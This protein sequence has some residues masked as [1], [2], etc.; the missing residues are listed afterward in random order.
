M[1]PFTGS[2]ESEPPVRARVS[3]A[4]IG[5]VRPWPQVVQK[6]PS[7]VAWALE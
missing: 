3:E 2:P 1:Q 7:M 6:D 4:V 5:L